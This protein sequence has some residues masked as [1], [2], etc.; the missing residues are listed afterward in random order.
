MTTSLDLITLAFGGFN[1]L[2]LASYLPQIIAVARDRHG[3]TAI[4]F[5]CWTIWVGANASTGL[6]AWAKL[7]DFNLAA[8]SAFNAACCLVVL[9]LAAYKRAVLVHGQSHARRRGQLFRPR[10]LSGGLAVVAVLLVGQLS[11]AIAVQPDVPATQADETLRAPIDTRRHAPAFSTPRFIDYTPVF[12]TDDADPGAAPSMS[13]VLSTIAIW[14][15]ESLALPLPRTAPRITLASP[16]RI[17]AMRYRTLG[18]GLPPQPDGERRMLDPRSGVVAVY[19]D[20]S[21]T[22]YLPEGWSASS[23]TDMSVLVHELVHH[24]QKQAQ[25]KFYCPQER[26]KLAYEAQERW[27]A[28][29][30]LS[31]QRAF[32]IDRLTLFVQT[33]CMM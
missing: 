10:H 2:R 31:L 12:T 16:A 33:S 25:L 20:A 28:R 23:P 27:L 29:S 13:S 26:E 22:I 3:A 30:G 32:E 24:L 7:H 18:P 11:T 14:L 21:E 17:T 4:S 15:N 19:D 1:L 9:L 5:S 6:Y 8:I